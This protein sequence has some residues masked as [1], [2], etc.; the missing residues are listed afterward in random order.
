MADG[1][2]GPPSRASV[3]R[4]LRLPFPPPT[5]PWYSYGMTTAHTAQTRSIETTASAS[6][7]SEIASGVIGRYIGAAQAGRLGTE[8][9]TD[10]GTAWIVAAAL[11]NHGYR[12]RVTR[13]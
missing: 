5:K 2:R 7:A 6:R 9:V 11:R 10:P 12:V 1:L 13:R 8:I 3:G 4:S